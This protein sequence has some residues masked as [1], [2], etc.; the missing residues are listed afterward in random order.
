MPGNC[1]NARL[2][3]AHPLEECVIRLQVQHARALPLVRRL[4]IDVAHGRQAVAVGRARVW[5]M[6]VVMVE[7]VSRQYDV[8]IV[9]GAD[10]VWLFGCAIFCDDLDVGLMAGPNVGVIFGARSAVIGCASGIHMAAS[11]TAAIAAAGASICV[12]HIPRHIPERV[13]IGFGI[14]IGNQHILPLITRFG[15]DNI[16][17]SATT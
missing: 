1:L 12:G 14:V 3:R 13:L 5:R 11:R 9:V 7:V 16:T 2:F 10:D 8:R 6:V 4:R 17:V 15:G